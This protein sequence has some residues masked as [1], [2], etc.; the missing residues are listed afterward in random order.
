MEEE[1][2]SAKH[3]CPFCPGN[4]VHTPPANLVLTKEMSFKKKI[5][6]LELKIGL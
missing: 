3:F 6:T 4:E 2:I 5:T 1:R